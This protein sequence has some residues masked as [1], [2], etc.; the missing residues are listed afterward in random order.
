MSAQRWLQA[1]RIFCRIY[2][3]KERTPI[4]FRAKDA[5]SVAGLSRWP[6]AFIGGLLVA[7]CVPL[8]YPPELN[9]EYGTDATTENESGSGGSLDGG[10]LDGGSLETSAR[11]V[12][13]DVDVSDDAAVVFADAPP[14][15]RSIDVGPPASDT[16]NPPPPDAANSPSPDAAVDSLPPPSCT[17]GIK[18]GTETAI[19]CGG[20]CAPARTCP[21]NQA[22]SK[23]ADC[24][25]GVCTAGTCQAPTCNDGV[26]NG[27]ETD[28]DCGGSCPGKCATGKKCTLA[29]HC[30]SN[31]CTAGICQPGVGTLDLVVNATEN[32][33]EEFLSSGTILV[34]S[35]DLE[36]DYDVNAKSQQIIGM[37]FVNVTIPPDAMITT[38]YVQFTAKDSSSKP[39]SVTIKGQAADNAPAFTTATGNLIARPTTT[40]SVAWSLIPAWIAD[41]ADATTRTPEI[42]TVLQEIV[43]RPGWASSN[44][45]VLL[46]TG[47]GGDRNAYSFD[48]RPIAA[49]RLHI[50]YQQ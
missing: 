22:C 30:V 24:G 9:G 34:D 44:A 7:S 32:D 6:V 23:A 48:G 40:T 41:I 20:S 12:A 16:P 27:G 15:D 14:S 35:T 39:S 17:D 46:L 11:D 19:D 4:I 49:P 3:R 50:E 47:D 21:N 31:I 13:A 36:L 26:L 8:G 42:K 33:A 18:N 43:S 25:S 10:S 37:R 29:S 1:R 5:R 45:L 38:A 2:R 28:V